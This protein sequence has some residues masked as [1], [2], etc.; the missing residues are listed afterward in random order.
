[1]NVYLIHH[2][3]AYIDDF[4]DHEIIA[5]Y[6]DFVD[7]VKFVT[8]FTSYQMLNATDVTINNRDIATGGICSKSFTLTDPEYEAHDIYITEWSVL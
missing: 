6:A 5:V 3:T 8:G 4:V 1:M 2:K 7:A